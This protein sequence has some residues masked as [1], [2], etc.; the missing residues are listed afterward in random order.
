MTFFAAH[1]LLLE[2]ISARIRNT[3][4][5]I[6]QGVLQAMS[7]LLGQVWATFGDLGAMLFFLLSSQGPDKIFE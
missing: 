1:M 5:C 2:C 3:V 7:E 4:V 6:T